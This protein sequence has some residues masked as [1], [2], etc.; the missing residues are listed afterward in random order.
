[1]VPVQKQNSELSDFDAIFAQSEKH[2][3]YWVENAILEYTEDVVAQMAEQ[4]VSRSELAVRLDAAPSFVSKM[5]SGSNNFTLRKMVEVARALRC[6]LRIHLQREGVRTS[7]RDYP[8][9]KKRA[10]AVAMT[11]APTI[12]TGTWIASQ[13]TNSAIAPAGPAM[14][15]ALTNPDEKLP[16]A[17]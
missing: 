14:S 10:H 13:L 2:P 17:A 15:N 16:L 11:V 9:K 8:L 12:E 6:E 1:M 4:K 7:W 5:L 3:E